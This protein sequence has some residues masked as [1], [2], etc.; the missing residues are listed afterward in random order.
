MKAFRSFS[1]SLA[2]LLSISALAE[3]K[4]CDVPTAKSEKDIKNEQKAK[5]SMIEGVFSAAGK[6]GGR[7]LKEATGGAVTERDTAG[8][9]KNFA[10]AYLFV[11][12]NG[13]AK[14]L[15]DCDKQWVNGE[16]EKA[17][18]RNQSTEWKSETTGTAG[19]NRVV[20]VDSA[21]LEKNPGK[22]CRTVVQNV[23]LAD[24]SAGSDKITACKGDDGVWTPAS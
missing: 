23:T 15:S 21:V 17:L 4:K 18:D 2:L 5:N 13:L 20:P 7:Y 8:L 19:E 12:E 11:P 14:N 9:G 16:T 1:V 24:G 22:L 6:F 3:D 10:R